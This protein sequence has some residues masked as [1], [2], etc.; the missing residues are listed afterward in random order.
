VLRIAII[1]LG[2]WGL[3]AL[4]RIASRLRQHSKERPA[5]ELHIVEPGRPGVGIYEITQPD[6]LLMNN[7]CAEISACPSDDTGNRS[8]AALGLHEWVV[9]S[10]YRWR[11]PFCKI[12]AEGT[13]IEP[14]DYLPRRVMGEYLQW[15]YHEVMGELAP[16]VTVAFHATHASDVVRCDDG[17]EAVH[18]ANGVRLVV[19]H[20]IL[21]FG[22]VPN[23]RLESARVQLAAPYP[24]AEHLDPIPPQAKVAITG[25][26]LVGVDVA[27]A[28]TIG[29]GG[30]FVEDGARVVY[31]PSGREPAIH[32]LSR[33]GLS[34]GAKT[35]TA[36]TLGF[37]ERAKPILLTPE[38]VRQLGR[39]GPG[40]IDF[41]RE[42]L[43]VLFDEMTA[44]YHLQS[45]FTAGGERASATLLERLRTAW[46]AGQFRNEVANLARSFGNFDAEEIFWGPR[47]PFASASDYEGFVYRSMLADIEDASAAASP[48]SAAVEALRVLRDAIRAIVEYGMLT[49]QSYREFHGDLRTRINRL[50][51]GHPLWRLRQLTALMDAGI[52]RMR[53]G[54][55]P[56]MM[57]RP[58]AATIHIR[59]T[60]LATP[61]CDDV[62]VAVRGFLEEPRV[63][64]SGSPL[65]RALY[66]RGRLTAFRY[67]DIEV[68]SVRVS[69][70]AHPI[71][72][73][74][75]IQHRLWLFGA[76]TEGVRYFT[77]YVPSPQRGARAF[78]DIGACIEQLLP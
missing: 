13:S 52:V 65:V 76:L 8:S 49:L 32:F 78:Q 40:S 50:V 75:E 53:F 18:L 54:P 10:G 67:D 24:V 68:G 63:D 11:G 3:C 51:A 29:R 14:D 9:R 38:V 39:R 66:G 27:W 35:T 30:C 23:A 42:V 45:A 26:G 48:R 36:G 16:K 77:H 69:P 59:S 44:R 47:R 43:P 21:T 58:E 1:G 70:D 41:R 72:S 74:G 64:A 56:E 28:L 19:D 25:M 62:D 46:S 2:P 73:R 55:A 20:V 31:R 4:E 71:D 33:S 7:A 22:H 6:Y 5:L 60:R 15:V 17:C 61:F 57:H 34:Y 12:G 37:P